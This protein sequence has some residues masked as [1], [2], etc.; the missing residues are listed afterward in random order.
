MRSVHNSVTE[1]STFL[2]SLKTLELYLENNFL[3]FLFI[4][5]YLLCLGRGPE[6]VTKQSY[7]TQVTKLSASNRKGD[8][9]LRHWINHSVPTAFSRSEYSLLLY[10]EISINL[11]NACLTRPFEGQDWGIFLC[12][13]VRPLFTFF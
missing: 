8:A 13:S 3:F 5:F 10:T 1:Q 12:F 6:L 9:S 2:N 4:I 11:N 7:P